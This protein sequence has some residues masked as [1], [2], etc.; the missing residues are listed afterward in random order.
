[1]VYIE[2]VDESEGWS[3]R[4]RLCL[5]EFVFCVMNYLISVDYAVYLTLCIIPRN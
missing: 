5:I 2:N 1:M 4:A 3:W